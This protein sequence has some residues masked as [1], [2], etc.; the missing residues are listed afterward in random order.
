M[1]MSKGLEVA[2]PSAATAAAALIFAFAALLLCR[3][4][5]QAGICGDAD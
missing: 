1:F 4:G 5:A 2:L 3:G